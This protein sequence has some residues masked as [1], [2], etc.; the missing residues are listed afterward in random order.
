MWLDA[1]G[2]QADAFII[3]GRGPGREEAFGFI[4]GLNFFAGVQL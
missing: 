1:G 4:R 3:A 2:G